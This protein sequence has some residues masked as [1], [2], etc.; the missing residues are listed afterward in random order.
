L[1]AGLVAGKRGVNQFR[2][3]AGVC[4]AQAGQRSRQFNQS[5]R[6]CL[7]QQANRA[8]YDQP[9]MNSR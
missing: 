9:A 3:E 6:R 8:N 4:L 1:P 5:P 7:F 2:V